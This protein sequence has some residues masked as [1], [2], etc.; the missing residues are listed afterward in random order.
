M[1]QPT[2]GPYQARPDLRHCA[3]TG[4]ITDGPFNYGIYGNGLRI[5]VMEESTSFR[6]QEQVVADARLL[7]AA[8]AM[9]QALRY[10]VSNA[11][12]PIVARDLAN[13]AIR[14]AAEPLEEQS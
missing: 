7:A 3:N 14:E 11:A 13:A 2:P 10:I 6:T 8:P 1:L 9:L 4:I 5:A 12:H